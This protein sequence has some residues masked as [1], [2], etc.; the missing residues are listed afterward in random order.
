MVLKMKEVL[1]ISWLRLFSFCKFGC[2]VTSKNKSVQTITN[3][4]ENFIVTLLGSPNLI[5]TDRGK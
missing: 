1:G 2:A 3:S 4:S 5:E